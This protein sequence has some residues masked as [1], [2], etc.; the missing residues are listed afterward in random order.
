ML[1]KGREFMEAKKSFIINIVFYGIVIAG[2]VLV[3]KYILPIMTPFIIAFA[4]AS[5]F[6]WL[7]KRMG[8]KRESLR[9]LVPAKERLLSRRFMP[10][11]LLIR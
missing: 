8:F 10:K 9:R 1:P 3:G 4:V 11:V 5:L 2:V 6:N 7:T